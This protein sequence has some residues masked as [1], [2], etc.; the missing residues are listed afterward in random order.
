MGYQCGKGTDISKFTL[1]DNL[2]YLCFHIIRRLRRDIIPQN[3]SFIDLNDYRAR[4]KLIWSRLLSMCFLWPQLSSAPEETPTASLTK[5]DSRSII[6]TK[7]IL[8][9]ALVIYLPL[10]GSPLSDTTVSRVIFIILSGKRIFL[11]VNL[12]SRNPIPANKTAIM[13]AKI[14]LPRK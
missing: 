14:S 3:C 9:W 1:P 2:P 11:A 5:P 10:Q 12:T 6:S 8:S 13:V 4:I 7:N